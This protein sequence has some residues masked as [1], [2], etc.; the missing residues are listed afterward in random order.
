MKA[1][2]LSAL[3]LLLATAALAADA[4]PATVTQE[5][6]GEAAIVAGNKDK[7]R[8]DARNA[9]LREA[10]EQV[11]G[12]LVTADT[13]T[14]N[15]QLVSDRV[16]A[17]SAGYVRSFETVKEEEARGVLRVTVRAEVG[18]A[19]LDQDL[20]AVQALVAALGSRK[21]VILTQEQTIDPGNVVTQ[22]SLMATTL[23]EAFKRDGWTVI[24]P[25]FAAG[26]LELAPGVA[27]NQA[28]VKQLGDLSKAD[29]VLY[30]T[31]VYRQQPPGRGIIPEV[32]EQGRQL[33]FLV[34]G[35][36]D[37]AVF[38]TDSGSQLAKVAGKFTS[39]RDD[40]GGPVV[41]GLPKR[42]TVS[43]ERTAF[44]ISKNRGQRIVSEVRAPV[45]ESLR[46]SQQ[47]GARVV[48]TVSG[49]ADYGA[50]QAFKRVL[51]ESIRGVREV[52]PGRYAQG[53]A[54]F[55]V[56]FLGSTD[57]LAEALGGK[58]FKGRRVAVTGV[59]GNTLE[60]TVGGR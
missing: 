49:L 25:H 39:G 22:S 7:A 33:L 52:R 47:N 32:D 28:Q 16:F 18:T 54:E 23:T 11:A 44:E 14:A 30:G 43:Y 55:D 15:A 35:E 50:V 4:V 57:E 41:A 21:L 24:D 13:L 12:V 5:V 48:M 42:A 2:T 34:S 27:L 40:V 45:I 20:Q 36:Y 9:A 29:Y 31:V 59:S 37:L 38:A 46:S 58:T 17:N 26:K 3:C 19:Q 10:V 6:T 60:L 56:T 8:R 1:L 53:R 51:A